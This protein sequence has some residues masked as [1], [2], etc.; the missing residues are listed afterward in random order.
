VWNYSSGT[1]NIV[2]RIVGDVVSGR[3]VDDV[4]E[5]RRAVTEFLR[6]R[7][8]DPCGM[9]SAT[10]GFDGAGDFVGSS[11]VYATACDFARFGELYRHDGVADLGRGPRVLPVG[12]L[13]H[14]RERVAT[15]PETGFGYGRHWWLWRRFPG[16]L[17]CHG[18]EGQYTLVVPDEELVLV[19]LGKTIREAQ[20][21]LVSRLARIADAVRGRRDAGIDTRS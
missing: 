16:S 13:D 7:L 9:T 4:D 20:P 1:T 10:A 17:A 2:A 11:F 5:R 6:D 3:R 12:W 21:Q 15:D 8:F 14:A 18:Y 19:H